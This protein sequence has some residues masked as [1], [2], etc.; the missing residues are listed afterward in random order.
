MSAA[1]KDGMVGK[2]I[3]GVNVFGGGLAAYAAD[4]T[5]AGPGLGVSGDSSPVADHVI[6]WHLRHALGLDHI[7]GGVSPTGDDNMVIDITN[8][9]SASGW[10]HPATSPAATEINVNALPTHRS[11]GQAGEIGDG[12]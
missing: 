6:C 4:G 1:E 3:G 5:L 10:G 12:G 11:G 8:G 2:R 7:P 9:V